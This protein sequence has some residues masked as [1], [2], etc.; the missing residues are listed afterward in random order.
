LKERRFPHAHVG[1]PER[2]IVD[3]T[4]S[5]S[6]IAA[7]PTDERARVAARVREL[8]AATPSLGEKSEVAY[9]YETRAHFCVKER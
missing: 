5:T 3:R 9:P 2:V 1:P 7:L 8:I 6:F 4:L